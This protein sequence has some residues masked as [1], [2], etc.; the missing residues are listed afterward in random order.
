[1]TA[2]K[3]L[4]VLLGLTAGLVA[5]G[6]LPAVAT[7]RATAPLAELTLS[8]VTVAAPTQVEAKAICTTRVHPVTGETTT[9]T[10]VKIEW[11]QSGSPGVTGYR[12]MA[13]LNDG[14][15]FVLAETGPTDE[16]YETVDK[17]LLDS[18]P[19]FS[20]TTLTD[21]GWTAESDTTGVRP[22]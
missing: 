4:V 1:M 17:G 11:W 14:S 21:Y 19:E 7:F 5:V 2:F 12:I 3:R 18:Q 9:T 13:Y 22:C 8:T 20:V 6:S 15:S 16:T 10:K